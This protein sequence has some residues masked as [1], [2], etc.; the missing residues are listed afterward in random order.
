[1]K[2]RKSIETV[3][4]HAGLRTDPATGAISTPIY[5]TATFGHP[6][7]GESTG[8]DYSRT[9]NPTRLVLERMLADLEQGN[10]AFAF[11]SGMAAIAS[12]MTLFKPGDKVLVSDDLYGGTYRLFE[13]IFKPWDLNAD[14]VDFSN[15][16]SVEKR[17][18]RSVKAFFVET[19]TNP[20]MKIADL[21]KVGRIARAHE[22]L[23]IVDN[24]FMTPFVSSRFLSVRT[25]WCTAGPNISPATTIRSPAW[26]WRKWP[27]LPK[28]SAL[29][30][31]PR[32]RCSR[33]SIPGWCCA[34][35]RPS[36][37]AWTALRKTP[38]KSPSG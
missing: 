24:T 36:P 38:R 18:D 16:P 8:F 22:A 13:K 17:I 33:H 3:L 4:S 28:K 25:S 2:S 34:G 12:L 20:L 6:R 29:R 26:S 1:M 35:S 11:S 19:P 37:F 5:Q 27:G 9:S 32:A 21:K 15:L 7:L 23:M 30:K 14:F 31:T 10:R